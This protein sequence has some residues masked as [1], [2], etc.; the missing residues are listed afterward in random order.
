MFVRACNIDVKHHLKSAFA[1][2]GEYATAPNLHHSRAMVRCAVRR[3]D[4]KLDGFL[5][6]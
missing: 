6:P 2:C 3:D 4:Q 5:D 1:K